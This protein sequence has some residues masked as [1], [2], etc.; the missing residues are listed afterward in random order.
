MQYVWKNLTRFILV[1]SKFASFEAHILMSE[2]SEPKTL[3]VR[4]SSY[5]YIVAFWFF[6][7]KGYEREFDVFCKNNYLI[8]NK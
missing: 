4:I 6:I 5:Y 1:L 7:S 3:Y 8:L 2:K